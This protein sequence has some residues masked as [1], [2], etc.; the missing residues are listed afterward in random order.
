MIAIFGTDQPRNTTVGCGLFILAAWAGS[1]TLG[2]RIR[3]RMERSYYYM[4]AQERRIG[5]G[6]PA[7]FA[8][9]SSSGFDIASREFQVNPPTF[10]VSVHRIFH[11]GVRPCL[12]QRRDY[13]WV[14]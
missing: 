1:P 8:G 4:I 5:Q 7:A 6:Y 14:R 9:G 13:H 2:G 11:L 3:V 10:F 12:A